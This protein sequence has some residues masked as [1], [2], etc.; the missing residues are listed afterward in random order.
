MTAP[1]APAAPGARVVHHGGRFVAEQDATLPVASLA[2]R[3]GLSV[4][5][6]IRLYRHDDGRV[7]PW[8][9][10][11]HLDRLAGSVDL[12]ELGDGAELVAG[13]GLPAV[14]DELVARNGVGTDAYCRV[15]VSASGAG[16]MDAEVRPV[17]TVSVAPSGRKRWLAEGTAMRAHLSDRERPG[18]RAFPPAAKCIS[19]YAGPRLALLE[20]RRL[21]YDVALLRSPAGTVSEAPTATVFAL[22]DGVLRTPPVRDGVLP[23]VTRA[24]VLAAAGEL[25]VE[26]EVATISADELHGAAEVFLCGTGIEFG[27]VGEVDGTVFAAAPG[28]VTK[29]LV[30]RYFAEVRGLAGP[31]AVAWGPGD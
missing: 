20:A 2:L 25:G 3:Y 18:E 24:W 13:A 28:P 12:V 22:V 4:F 19:A 1:A 26:R 16:L 27:P 5:E 14:I 31:V 7:V 6:G 10:D 29:A 8:L 17:V 15:A 21:G 11:Q 23:G 30:D 9:L